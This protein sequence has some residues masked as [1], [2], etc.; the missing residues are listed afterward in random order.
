[1]LDIISIFKIITSNKKDLGSRIYNIGNGKKIS[2][3]KYIKLIEKNLM[4][5]S[6]KK[7]LSTERRYSKTHSDTSLLKKNMIIIPTQV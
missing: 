4:K 7:F 5:K 1:M 3:M 2:L 6:K